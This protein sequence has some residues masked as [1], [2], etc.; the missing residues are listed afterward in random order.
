MANS[1]IK[2][3]KRSLRTCK[4]CGQSYDTTKVQCPSCKRWDAPDLTT[5]DGT[6]LLSEVSPKPLVRIPGIGPWDRCFSYN[7][8]THECGLVTVQ[9]VLIGGVPGAGKSTLALQSADRI[10]EI[11]GKEI[12]YIAAEEADAQIKDRAIRLGV[13]HPN[14]IRVYPLGATAD[15][16]EVF[17]KR[18]PA[19]VIVDSLPGLTSDLSQAVAMCKAFKEYAVVMGFP[20]IIIDHANKEETLAGLMALQHEVDTTML[21]T[22]F[23]DKKKTRQLSNMKNRFG[24]PQTIYLEMTEFGLIETEEYDDD[25]DDETDS[26][27]EDE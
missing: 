21:F 16:G 25:D 19:A 2:T 14:K 10:A 7:Q 12:I 4:Y 1:R 23:E 15:L 24:P 20:F 13:K 27:W 11:T 3:A 26:D 8:T 9:T 17:Q 22:V 6:V 5:D 18:K